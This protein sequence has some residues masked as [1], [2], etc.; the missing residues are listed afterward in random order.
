MINIKKD[1]QPLFRFILTGIA[2]LAV[3]YTLY[4]LYL[5][6]HT[7]IDRIVIDNLGDLSSF[8][9]ETLGYKL[10]PESESI[11]TVGVDGT[12][13][14]WIGDSCNGIIVLAVY[15]IFIISFPGSW[16]KKLWFIP[17]GMIIIH[18][19]N[20]IRITALALIVTI[21]YDLL[22]FNHDY[23]FQ[24]L[25]WGTVFLLW[26]KWINKHAGI[27]FKKTDETLS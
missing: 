22:Q 18:L 8:C 27:D 6:P 26:Y 21:D 7:N 13:G 14:V 9:L 10:I 16:K 15:I 12:H 19:V 25:V 1:N 11:R 3:W 5:H 4:Y 20:V 17:M 24:L 23:T 2:L